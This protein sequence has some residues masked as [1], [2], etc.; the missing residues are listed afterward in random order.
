MTRI[1]IPAGKPP[2]LLPF[3]PNEDQPSPVDLRSQLRS[4]SSSST[5]LLTSASALEQAL[6]GTVSPSPTPSPETA[7]SGTPTDD[8]IVSWATAIRAS[9][10]AGHI[11]TVSALK[12]WVRYTFQ[13]YTPEYR[14]VGERLEA[15]LGEGAA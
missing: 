9:G 5:G 1:L 4:A 11:Y 7:P 8:Q 2:V 10:E 12:Y 3:G 6:S 13:S 14:Y 15:L